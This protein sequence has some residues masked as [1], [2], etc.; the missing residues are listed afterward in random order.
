MTSV[1]SRVAALKA[2]EALIRRAVGED[3][4]IRNPE[5]P[6]EASREGIVVMSDGDP[7]EAE[8]ILSPLAFCWEHQV[9]I[10]IAAS[11]PDRVAVTEGLLARL[12]PELAADRRLGGAVDDARLMSAPEIHD[13][14]IDDAETERSITVAVQLSPSVRRAEP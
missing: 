14:P 4:F 9:A 11:G 13:Y 3:I 6:V 8:Y 10:E 1:Q 2:L 5:S 7:G 12:E